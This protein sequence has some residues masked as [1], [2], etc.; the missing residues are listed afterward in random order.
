MTQDQDGTAIAGHFEVAV[1]FAP[2]EEVRVVSPGG[3]PAPADRGGGIPG[4]RE[5]A[6]N[7]RFWRGQEGQQRP[8]L[9]EKGEE[10]VRKATEALA[11]QIG[12]TAKLIAEAI[13]RQDAAALPAEPSAFGLDSVEVQYGVTLSAGLQTVFTAQAE[14]S[15]QVTI[16]LTR[17]HD[18]IS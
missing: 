6:G 1:A 12:A 13:G 15:V 18:K 7:L 4:T 2:V 9:V 3:G 5:A 8:T 10:V 11:G 16:T 14:S 17:N